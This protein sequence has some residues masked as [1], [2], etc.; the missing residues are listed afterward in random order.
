[1]R[2]IDLLRSWLA[3]AYGAESALIDVMETQL[4]D[5]TGQHEMEDRVQEHL[6]QLHRHANM[7][8][9]C[10]MRLGGETSSLNKGGLPTFLNSMKDLWASPVSSTLVKNDIVDVAAV[11]YEIALLNALAAVARGSGDEETL[12]VCQQILGEKQEMA[13][14]FEDYAPTLVHQ[15]TRTLGGGEDSAED[16]SHKVDAAGTLQKRRLYAVVDDDKTA[17]EAERAIKD[18][19]VDVERLEGRSAAAALS[20]EA[21]GPGSLLQKSVRFIKGAA[22]ETQQAEHYATHVENGRIVLSMPSPDRAAADKLIAIVKE[23]GG[24]DLAYFSDTTMESIE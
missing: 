1:M 5:L 21:Q 24:Y 9:D 6:Q 17:R 12:R 22:G 20:Q 2:Q 18:Q 15:L 10:V 11:H 4:A 16:Q 3:D 23:H 19:G 7:L 8:Q 13:R 14:W